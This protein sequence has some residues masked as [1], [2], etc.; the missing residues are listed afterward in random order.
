MS[1]KA[2]VI[3]E[4]EEEEEEEEEFYHKPTSNNQSAKYFSNT[5]YFVCL[6]QTR[7]YFVTQ[8][9]YGF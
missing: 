1:S 3:F 7:I 6:F 2:G 8:H 5:F 4:G 9:Y